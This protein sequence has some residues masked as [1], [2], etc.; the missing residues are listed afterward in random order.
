MSEGRV[1]TGVRIKQENVAK[2]DELIE[3]YQGLTSLGS[4]RKQDVVDLA[5]EKLYEKIC[6]R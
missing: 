3:H 1:F 5:I 6:Y 2:I 4:V